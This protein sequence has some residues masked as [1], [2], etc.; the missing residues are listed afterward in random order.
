MIGSLLSLIDDREA[1]VCVILIPSITQKPRSSHH[2]VL[3][4]C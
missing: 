4:K 1:L 3:S 2:S